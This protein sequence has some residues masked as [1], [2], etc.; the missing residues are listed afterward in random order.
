MERYQRNVIN[1]DDIV[2]HR[3]TTREFSD[4]PVSID[5]INRII[6]SGLHAPYAAASVSDCSNTNYF[7]KFFVIPK[8]SKTM[9]KLSKLAFDGIMSM[10][11]ML[12]DIIQVTK[13]DPDEQIISFVAK[14]SI[15]ENMGFVPGIGN[16]P[17]LIIVAERKGFPP[18]QQSSLAHCLE[19]MWLKATVLGLG[20]QL[21]SIIE[22]CEDNWNFYEALGF[23]TEELDNWEFN[24]CAIGYPKEDSWKGSPRP[25]VG[26]VTIYRQ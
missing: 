10:K 16:T 24:G 6:Q 20:F 11:Q 15:F 19:N 18:I 5:D 25:S 1:F 17:Y 23:E 14:L 2:E 22:R 21:V 3:V 8:G 12:D 13:T 9:E 4:K 7:R 26:D